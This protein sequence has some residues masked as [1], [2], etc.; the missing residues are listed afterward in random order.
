MVEQFVG[1]I[2]EINEELKSQVKSTQAKAAE[3]YKSA[4]LQSTMVFGL[5][6]KPIAGVNAPSITSLAIATHASSISITL[7]PLVR[8]IANKQKYE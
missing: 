5:D 2:K 3:L 1:R 4:R 8:S 6:D 7:N